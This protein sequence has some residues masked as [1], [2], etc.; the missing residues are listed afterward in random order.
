VRKARGPRPARPRPLRDTRGRAAVDQG[1]RDRPRRRRGVSRGMSVRAAS[2][3]IPYPELMQLAT[4]ALVRNG[5][6]PEHAGLI[7]E[8]AVESDLGGRTSHGVLRIAGYLAK[9]REGGI[10]PHAEPVVL[11]DNGTVFAIDARNG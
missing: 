8:S 11:Q 6:A 7:A 9:A 2:P 10:D 3:T 5:V 4:D 1:A